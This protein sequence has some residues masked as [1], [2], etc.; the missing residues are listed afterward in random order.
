MYIL[1]T[2]FIN[3]ING[4]CMHNSLITFTHGTLIPEEGPS[5]PVDKKQGEGQIT[6][7]L[8]TI[9]KTIV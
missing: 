3:G 7:P 9:K 6:F 2:A 1:D 8:K 4:W 5:D